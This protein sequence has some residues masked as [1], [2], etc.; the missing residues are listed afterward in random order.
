MQV[1]ETSKPSTMTQYTRHVRQDFQI[2]QYRN[3]F[4][5]TFSY[6]DN[7]FANT[8]L[9]PQQNSPSV[10]AHCQEQER[11]IPYKGHQ[12]SS[13]STTRTQSVDTNFV[14]SNGSTLK[15]T[16]SIV[17]AFTGTSS[18]DSTSTELDQEI[19]VERVAR[20]EKT[21]N[22]IT[23]L[24]NSQF[25]VQ[26]KPFPQ[27]QATSSR[28]PQVSSLHD[29]PAS[30]LHNSQAFLLHDLTSTDKNEEPQDQYMMLRESSRLRYS[31]ECQEKNDAV[32]IRLELGSETV[33]LTSSPAQHCGLRGK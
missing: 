32:R 9:V 23:E 16:E 26:L 12:N 13:N 31:T 19:L 18:A 11:Y 22:R 27:V 28:D 7:Q 15:S 5:P 24:A 33:G 21:L 29:L 3:P 4:V 8:V 1:Q 25:S 30:L 10:G 14:R 17:D 6:E 2:E 20:L